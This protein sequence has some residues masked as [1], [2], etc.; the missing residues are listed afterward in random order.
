MK[1]TALLKQFKNDIILT[2]SILIVAV[3]VFFIIGLIFPKGSFVTIQKDGKTVTTLPL[4]TDTEIKIGDE[5]DYNLLIIQ[6]GEAYIKD[7]SC[8][9]KLCIHQ[10]KVSKQGETLVCLP[11]KTVI[12]VSSKEEPN[13]DFVQ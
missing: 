3:A 11:N 5:E 1:K 13:T 9:D 10:G 2:A 12:T 7:A 6:N 4:D 8:P